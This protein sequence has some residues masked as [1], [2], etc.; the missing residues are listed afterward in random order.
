MIVIDIA[1]G[2]ADH[3]LEMVRRCKHEFPQTTVIAGNVATAKGVL[4]LAEAGA[5]AVKVGVGSGIDLHHA[6][7]DRFW[8]APADR[9]LRLRRRSG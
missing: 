3:V 5:D 1:H 2:H 8:R 4:D 7:R 9:H 6:H